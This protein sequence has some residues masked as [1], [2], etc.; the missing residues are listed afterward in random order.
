MVP[1][2]S[3]AVFLRHNDDELRRMV[4]KICGSLRYS[5]SMDDLIQDVYFKFVSAKTL[6]SYNRH[7]STGKTYSSCKLSTFLYPILRNFILSKAESIDQ[8]M[9]YGTVQNYDC[10]GQEVDLDD[11]IHDNIA[12]EYRNLLAQNDSSDSIHGLSFDFKD[13]ERKLRLSAKN[14]KILKRKKNAKFP[15]GTLLKIFKYLYEGYSC[16]EIADIYGVSNMKITLLKREL[17]Q[18]MLDL[19]F[20][21]AG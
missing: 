11:T 15:Q 16:K 3:I 9:I 10:E 12:P 21:F 7:Y 1:T 20:D 14:K 19:G 18:I 4:A 8:K 2:N 5:C 6:Q 13:F 17:G